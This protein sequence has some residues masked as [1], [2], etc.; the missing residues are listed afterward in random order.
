[1]DAFLFLALL[2]ILAGAAP[3]WGVD[4]HP[5]VSAR[6]GYFAFDSQSRTGY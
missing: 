4:S 3:H 6:E 2:L 5:S 1:M